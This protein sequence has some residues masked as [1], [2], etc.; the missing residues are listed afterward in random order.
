[1][2][3]CPGFILDR[4]S[5]IPLLWSA[6]LG[7]HVPDPRIIIPILYQVQLYSQIGR[8]AKL[9]ASRAGE[10]RYGRTSPCKKSLRLSLTLAG[11]LCSRGPY[12]FWH[13]FAVRLYELVDQRCYLVEGEDARGMAIEHGGVIDVISPPLQRRPDREVLDRR[14][15]G[16]GRGALRRK[17]P[18]VA[19][20]QT[21]P[22]DQNRHLDATACREVGN[23]ARVLDAAAQ[24][25]V[26]SGEQFA[27]GLGVLDEV[28]FAA[29]DVLVYRHVVEFDEP[30]VLEE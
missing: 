17:I 24:R 19:G 20:T 7:G 10:V 27:T 13:C 9:R 4:L 12:A 28:L 1:M 23:Q 15:G 25:E 11:D 2:A 22:V 3:I 8:L 14:V 16:A 26:L 21:G 29:P 18:Y 6:V 30:V 5:P